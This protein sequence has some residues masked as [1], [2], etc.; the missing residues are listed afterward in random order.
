MFGQGYSKL[1][2]ITNGVITCAKPNQKTKGKFPFSFFHLQSM[3]IFAKTIFTVM[4]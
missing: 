4:S 2:A 1:L 3:K